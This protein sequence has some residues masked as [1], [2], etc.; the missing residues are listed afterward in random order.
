M[1]RSGVSDD[2]LCDAVSEMEQ[3]LFD[4]ELGGNVYKKRVAIPGRGKRAGARTLVA[5]NKGSRW[6]FVFG[7]KKSERANISATELHA[8][9]ALADDLLGL[10]GKKLNKSVED[11]ELTE[12]C[13][14]C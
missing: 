5:T 14:D 10:S 2:A 4:A 13:D 1:A 11:G 9:K 12:I 3:G 8:L 6:F 7:F